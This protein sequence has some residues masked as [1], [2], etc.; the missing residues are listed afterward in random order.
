LNFL[1]SLS[2]INR[3]RMRAGGSNETLG[4]SQMDVDEIRIGTTYADVTPIAVPEPASAF[5]GLVGAALLM[6]R[7]RRR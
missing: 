3:V 5:A 4:A 2:E 7:R 1:E 6:A